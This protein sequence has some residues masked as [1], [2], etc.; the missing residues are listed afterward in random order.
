[1]SRRGLLFVCVSVLP[2]VALAL[3]A[4]SGSDS[5]PQVAATAGKGS[6]GEPGG[7]GTAGKASGGSATAG[8][9]G[10]AGGV[11]AG[12][13]NAGGA[14]AEAGMGGGGGALAGSAG[15]LGEGG[16][17]E[18]CSPGAPG[19][20]GAVVSSCQLS[21]GVHVPACT[22]IVY[23][24]NP[25]SSGEHYPTWADF[26][27]YDFPLPRGYWMHNLEHGAVVVTYNC[28]NGCA[29]ELAAAK[30]WLAALTPDATCPAGPA[31]ILLV[32]DPLL[33][34]T[35]AASSWGFTLRADC[36]DAAVFSKFFSDHAGQAIAPEAVLCGTGFDFRTD[37]ADV[38]GAK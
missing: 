23:S 8:T 11:D 12:G 10:N 35:W 24:S 31:R 30:T 34:V 19:V 25:P 38:C 32:P 1:M 9:S 36:F 17:P 20:C 4:C 3:A 27:V 21:T 29:E 22:P 16:A 15:E 13:V 28:P 26:G 18:V 14:P 33:D 37:G 6:A 5:H 2:C 7:A